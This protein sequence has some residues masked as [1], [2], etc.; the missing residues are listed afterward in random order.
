MTH[1][2]ILCLSCANYEPEFNII[3]DDDKWYVAP[4]SK[5]CEQHVTDRYIVDVCR[6]SSFLC[7]KCL[8]YEPK[9][10]GA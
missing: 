1:E 8:Q 7:T 5:E 9:E 2:P 10:R 3:A 4:Q 6:Q